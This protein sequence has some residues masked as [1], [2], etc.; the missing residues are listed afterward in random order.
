MSSFCSPHLWACLL[1]L[2]SRPALDGTPS[3]HMA[4][5]LPVGK[6][7][8]KRWAFGVAHWL[9]GKDR[10]GYSPT[11]G[12]CHGCHFNVLTTTL[13]VSKV[14]DE[15]R[16][17]EEG[18]STLPPGG[19]A[20]CGGD[21]EKAHGTT[22]M[23]GS[24]TRHT[25]SSPLTCKRQGLMTGGRDRGESSVKSSLGKTAHEYFWVSHLLPPLVLRVLSVRQ[26]LRPGGE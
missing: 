9:I 8:G 3:T 20:G 7:S 11:F 16:S 17:R 23:S 24:D 25:A 13:V 26:W 12:L 15:R 4:T 1:K 5:F 10:E 2:L 14:T 22:H 21:G 6:E 18:G 19:G